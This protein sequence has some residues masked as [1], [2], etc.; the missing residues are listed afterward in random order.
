MLR[1]RS[2]H[3]SEKV[4]AASAAG[5]AGANQAEVR[6]PDGIGEAGAPLRCPAG[7]AL[8]AR[9]TAAGS[10]T[11]STTKPTP[12][13]MPYAMRSGARTPRLGLTFLTTSQSG[14]AEG[15]T[16]ESPSIGVVA[17]C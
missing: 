7:L 4:G 15:R 6:R 1:W 8:P 9:P 5:A 11:A 2:K 10:R 16:K 3:E 12:W 13:P 17:S 14:C